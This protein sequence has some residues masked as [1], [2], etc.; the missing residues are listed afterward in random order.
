LFR[1]LIS[2]CLLSLF[3]HVL[4]ILLRQLRQTHTVKENISALSIKVTTYSTF[5]Q[6]L[7]NS[8]SLH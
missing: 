1:I 5:Q 4:K 2:L 7:W 3:S 8:I 6:L